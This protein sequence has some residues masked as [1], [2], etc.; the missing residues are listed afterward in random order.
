MGNYFRTITK[1]GRRRRIRTGFSIHRPCYDDFFAKI[2][3]VLGSSYKPLP[4]E[5]EEIRENGIDNIDNR[6]DDDKQCFKW[7]Q[8]R[9][10]FPPKKKPKKRDNVVTKNLKNQSEKLNWDGINFPTPT[11]DIDIFDNLNKI[12]TMILGWDDDKKRVTN[13]RLPKRKYEK[14]S[15]LFYYDNHYSSVR[16]LPKLLRPYFHDNY[17]YFRHYCTF[18]HRTKDVVD[19][20]MENCKMDKVTIERMPKEGSIVEFNNY[21]EIVL[22]PFTIWADYECRTEKT[23]IQ[24]GDKTELI[25]NHKPS[26]YCLR[27][28]SRVDETDNCT[29]NYP[30]KTD[31]ENVSEHFLKTVVNLVKKIGNKYAVDKP[32]VLTGEEQFEFDNATTCWICK[33]RFNDDDGNRKVREI[34]VIIPVN[35]A[36]RHTTCVI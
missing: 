20:H 17:R 36:V 32:L 15:Q 12:S 29:L 5:L 34:I 30:A 27:L 7:A 3:P 22:K 25:Q 26:G 4:K 19:F 11:S 35:I 8:T 1:I 9:S 2:G 31:E 28:V 23:N 10:K 16:D 14:T 6:K 21:N 18:Q 33:G 13:L 24:K